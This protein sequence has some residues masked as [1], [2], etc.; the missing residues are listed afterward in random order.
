MNKKR[1]NLLKIKTL[2]EKNK[3]FIG[4]IVVSEEFLQLLQDVA[5]MVDIQTKRLKM[6]M[7][8]EFN[9]IENKSEDYIDVTFLYGVPCDISTYI[10]K[11]A[12]LEMKNGEHIVLKNI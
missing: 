7:E 4:R 5:D 12:I 9:G 3:D 10:V 1:K 11:G 8:H 2:I 6:S